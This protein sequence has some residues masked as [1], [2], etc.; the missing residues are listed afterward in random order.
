MANETPAAPARAGRRGR[1]IGLALLVAL[2]V[3]PVAALVVDRATRS[4][5]FAGLAGPPDV[6]RVDEPKTASWKDHAAGSPMRLAILLTDPDSPWLGLVH[7]LKALGVPFTVTRDTGEALRHRVVMLYP[8]VSGRVLPPEDLR[9]LAAHPRAGGTLIGVNVLGGLAEVFGFKEAVASRA[10]FSVDLAAAADWAGLTEPEER[11][12][13]LG[14]P[15]AGTAQI[16]THAYTDAGEVLARFDDGSAAVTRRRFG[17]GAAYAL[18]FD[19]GALLLAGQTARGQDLE[20]AYVNAYV[21]QGEAILRLIRRIWRDGE[22]LAVSLGRVPQGKSLAVVLTHDVDY[23][24]SLPNA[25]AYAELLRENGIRGTFLIQTKYRRDYNDAIILTDESAQHLRRLVALGMELGSHTVVHSRAFVRFPIG[26]GDERYPEYQPVSIGR[27]EAEGGTILGELRVSRY[28]VER[29]AP[30]ARVVSF[31]PGHLAYPAALPQALA[32]TGYAFSSSVTAGTAL[33]H[34][35]Y[36]MTVDRS[37]AAATSV[38]EF[39][40][41]IEDEHLPLMGLRLAPALE[42]ARKIGRDG[43]A[44]V[45]LT[46]PNILGHKLDFT[47]GL[48]KAL[49]DSAWFGALDEFGAWWSARDGLAL[50]ASAEGAAAQVTIAPRTGQAVEGVALEVPQGWRLI[51]GQGGTGTAALTEPDARQLA[52]GR[53][54]LARIAEPA[55]LRFSRALP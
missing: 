33:T 46:H 17:A 23:T 8:L 42:V 39:P 44:L 15:E 18:G 14:N 28:L 24:R 16:G 31:R 5:T 12:L 26:T 2:F 3:M 9:R 29:L 20:R 37:A 47:R 53:V 19:P 27:E 22:P 38:F 49:R 30:P 40:I 11:V 52:D 50:D 10:R 55:V 48:I 51:A 1:L 45:V 4:Y 25:V 7:G 6:S 35:P 21:P 36:R 54:L 43:G 34:L 41:T 32:A 13:R